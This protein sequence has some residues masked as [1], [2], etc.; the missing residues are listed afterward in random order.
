MVSPSSV[1]GDR[2]GARSLDG[3]GDDEHTLRPPVPGGNDCGAPV[4]LG[5]RLGRGERGGE[6]QGPLRQQSFAPDHH[7]VAVD[8]AHDPAAAEVVERGRRG[9]GADVLDGPER[10][11]PGDRMLRRRLQRPGEPQH[12]RALGVLPDVHLDERMRPVVTVPVLSSTIVSTRRVDSSTSGPLI[13]T[14]S[15]A[16]RPVPTSSAVGV[17]GPAHTDRR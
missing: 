8:G 7:V 3:V 15:C 6:A 2:L 5:L 17:A 13:R 11:G 1:N 9:E 16:P 12:V 14:P 4:R 10:D